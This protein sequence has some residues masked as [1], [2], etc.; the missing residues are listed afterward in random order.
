MPITVEFEMDCEECI[1][2]A[3]IAAGIAYA[4]SVFE[5]AGMTPEEAHKGNL[6][7]LEA[8]GMPSD[9]WAKAENFGVKALSESAQLVFN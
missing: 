2:P 9:V 4:L 5:D 8:T 3:D 6:R 7:S 1:E